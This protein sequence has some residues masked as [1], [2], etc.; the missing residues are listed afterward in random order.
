LL[1]LL[2]SFNP[3]CDAAIARA[4]DLLA[5]D[6]NYLQQVSNELYQKAA[7][8]DEI[9][10][11]PLR[12]SHRAVGRRAL[13]IWLREVRGDLRRIDAGHLEAIENLIIAGR[14]GSGVEIPGGRRIVREFERLVLTQT[15]TD[16]TKEPGSILLSEWTNVEFGGFCFSLRR[17]VPRE[18]LKRAK[19]RSS[20]EFW[21]LIRE[22]NALDDLR[23][24]TRRP[25][26]AYTPQGRSRKIKL[27]SLMIR[28]KIPLSQRH[29]YPVA[30]TA[31]DQIIWSPGLPVARQFAPSEV[32]V[33]ETKCALIVAKRKS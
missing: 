32:D 13:R 11:G 5:D 27:K 18:S 25:G 33:E 26:D 29:T 8:G 14:S 9:E 4:A 6:E 19:D 28:H 7:Q 10:I 15:K 17:N 21:A 20:G 22:C 12:Q 30:T 1:P 2:R 23:L 31:E 24:R 16:V 3:R